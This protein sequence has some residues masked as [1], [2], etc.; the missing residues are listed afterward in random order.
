M[1]N[2]SSVKILAL[3]LA[4]V[5][6]SYVPTVEAYG[7]TGGGRNDGKTDLSLNSGESVSSSIVLVLTAAVAVVC[8]ALR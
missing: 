8:V 6:L 2:V 1:T 7:T 5:V 3:C 4:L